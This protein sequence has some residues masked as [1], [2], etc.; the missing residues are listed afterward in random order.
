MLI[1]SQGLVCDVQVIF[2]SAPFCIIVHV[3]VQVLFQFK[4]I[5]KTYT[6]KIQIIYNIEN[7][8]HTQNGN[9]S[10][11]IPELYKVNQQ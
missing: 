6:C 8:E 9:M 4:S 3:Q 2:Y 7:T 5:K 1:T 10:T 11:N